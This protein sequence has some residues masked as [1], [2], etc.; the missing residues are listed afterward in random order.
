LLLMLMT[1]RVDGKSPVEY[2]VDERKKQIIRT[3]VKT[4]LT[5]DFSFEPVRRLSILWA[6]TIKEHK[7]NKHE[8]SQY[9]C[10]SDI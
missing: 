6:N 7:E 3:F 5:K 2:L 10:H 4:N 9:K 8:N 1:A